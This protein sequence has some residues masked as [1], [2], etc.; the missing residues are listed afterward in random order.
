MISHNVSGDQSPIT[1]NR[2]N[3]TLYGV[4]PGVA[5]HVEITPFMKQEYD[6]SNESAGMPVVIGECR[7]YF[8]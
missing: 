6:Q 8:T 5:Y 2:T 3:V 4:L 1:V 7:K